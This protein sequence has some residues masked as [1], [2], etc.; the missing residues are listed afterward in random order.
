M[1]EPNPPGEDGFVVYDD[2]RNI[3]VFDLQTGQKKILLSR[4]ELESQ[5]PEDRSIDSSTVEARVP[6]RVFLSPDFRKARISI[7]AN[8]DEDFRCGFREFVYD[9]ASKS[10]IELQMPSAMYGVDWQ[11]SP[12][13]SKLAGTG[14]TYIDKT[15]TTPS[16]FVINSDGTNLRQLSTLHTNDW[17][18]VWHPG[19]QAILPMTVQT[20]FDTVLT[21]GSGASK[22]SI[23]EL[24]RNDKMECLAFSPDYQQ[25]AFVTRRAGNAGRDWAYISR[26]DFEFPAMVFEME[27]D[28]RYH[29][30][31]AW[32]PNQKFLHVHYRPA[33][34]DSF[35]LELQRTPLP[36]RDFVYDV[37]MTGTLLNLP[38]S[39]TMCGWTPDNKLIYTR[40]DPQTKATIVELFDPATATTFD[41]PDNLQNSL[42]GCPIAWM[43]QLTLN[44][45]EE[46]QVA[47][48]CRPGE[49]IQD[50]E[51]VSITI[52]YYNILEVS[53]SLE[54]EKLSAAVK[55]AAS[56]ADLK[57]YLTPGIDN[58]TNGWDVLVDIDNNILT[59]DQAGI[60]YRLVTSILPETGGNRARLGGGIL[61]F[62]EPTSSYIPAGE[63]TMS[64]DASNNM[65][66]LSG[67]VPGITSDSRIVIT[68]RVIL[69]V[70]DSRPNMAGDIVCE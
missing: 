55:L 60:E 11:W 63:L 47:N 67:I 21:D 44:L 33:W 18:T 25:T 14:W 70:K 31:I 45:P 69:S 16:Y 15:F 4:Q 43:D 24:S 9:V 10:L 35:D 48:V 46:A 56:S 68:S 17:R 39:T 40:N 20:R 27:I 52:P 34:E 12:D 19:G 6:L 37:E 13:G 2:T 1:N 57:N 22:I 3:L 38:E 23:E 54:G 32:S 66:T 51:E 30:E 41:L 49:T 58:F 64:L 42:R 65:L 53:T 59:G 29:C 50:I 26:S 61:Q 7:C 62:S 36:P 5:L 8:L 28:A